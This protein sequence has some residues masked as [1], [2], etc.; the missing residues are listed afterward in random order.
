MIASA[1]PKYLDLARIRQPVPA[2][3]S[4]L[5]R[6]SGAALFLF[7]GVLLYLFQE[8]LAS[9][10]SYVR[11]RAV[12]DHWL[13]KL[14]LTGMLWAFLHHFFAGLRFLLLDV[15]I[16]SELRTTRAMSWGVLGTSLVLTVVLGVCLW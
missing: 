8:S 9:P 10:E 6:I 15:D 3:V 5:H 14:F 11:F 7:A 16:G 2:V 4:I 13:A 1:R 12:A